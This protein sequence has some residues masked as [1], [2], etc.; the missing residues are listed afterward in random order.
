MR[1]VFIAGCGRSGTTLL[2]SILG[3]HPNCV[4]IPEAQFKFAL[5]NL[6]GRFEELPLKVK[7][8][9]MRC[10]ASFRFWKLAVDAGL[11]GR[12]E[13]CAGINS[14]M[15]ELIDSYCGD[16]SNSQLKWWIDHTPEN[17][18]NVHQLYTAYDRPKFIHI[19]RDGRAVA[20]S[21]MP[22][23]WGPNTAAHAAGWWM[24]NVAFGLGAEQYFTNNE[25]YRIH[26]EQ[27]VENP[28]DVIKSVCDF[29]EI[30]FYPQMIGGQEYRL[31]T[32]T[33][34]QHKLVGKPPSLDRVSKWRSELSP[35][36]IYKFESRAGGLLLSL[37]YDLLHTS[38]DPKLKISYLSNLGDDLR[39]L[40]RIYLINQFRIRWRRWSNS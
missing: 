32:Y 19:V 30:D 13:A 38:S 14:W 17:I 37:G 8:D 11:V 15:L 36:D 12:L 23:D 7:I 27:L 40:S 29:L 20:S 25:V 33:E 21:V 9:R 26:Y 4:A 2:G 34:K 6:D 10:S 31:P 22:L 28:A 3:S 1:P 39:N 24:G 16:R 18:A 35:L 5:G